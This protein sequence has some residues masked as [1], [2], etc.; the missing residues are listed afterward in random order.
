MVRT[1]DRSAQVVEHVL[2]LPGRGVLPVHEWPGPAGAPV[3]VLV[4][5]VTLDWRTNWSQVC[6]AL[7]RQFRVL[8]LD[9]RGH[10][11]GLP[12][13]PYR[14]EDCADDV[15]AVA[16]ALGTGP[17]V[18]VG[19]S[20]GGMIAQLVWHRHPELTA[21]LVLCSTARDVAG[22]Y[23]EQAVTLGMPLVVATTRFLSPFFPV[24]ADS[25][26]APLLDA[27]LDPQARQPA[28]EQMRRTPLA[29]ALDAMHA[30]SRFSSHRWIGG[31]DVPTA[32]LVTRHD[33]VVAPR[34]QRRLAEAVPGATIVEIDGDHG[35]FLA[36]PT[37]FSDGLLAA[38]AAATAEDPPRADSAA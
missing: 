24:G 13:G 30:V 5:G 15:A 11:R 35:V 21:G 29:T 36:D 34:R 31:V 20:M 17:V 14:L 23:W 8:A 19:Y 6:P 25:I 9:M 26:A 28:L 22:T 18:V 27:S 37:G 1:G 32:V 7:S 16:V 4:H 3:L 33:R 12:A 38:C 2:D 10:G